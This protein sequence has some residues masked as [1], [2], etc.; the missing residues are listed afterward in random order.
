MDDHTEEVDQIRSPFLMKKCT[1]VVNGG[2]QRCVS[3]K[4][5]IKSDA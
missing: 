1:G 2:K 4:H 5:R 3:G